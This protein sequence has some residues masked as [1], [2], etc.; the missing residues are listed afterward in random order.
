MRIWARATSITTVICLA[1]L[2]FTP[3]ARA[4]TAYR[5][6]TFWTMSN[7]QWVFSQVGP[8]S[9]TPV[10]GDVQAWRFAVSTSAS[11]SKFPPRTEPAT[12]FKTICGS[13]VKPEGRIRVAM[14]IDPGVLDSAPAGQSPPPAR[15]ACAVIGETGSGAEALMTIATPRVKGGM[16][17]GIDDYPLGECVLT[18]DISAT[19]VSPD[20]VS[21]VLAVPTTGASHEPITA[22]PASTAGSPVPLIAVGLIIAFG[23]IAAWLV[24]RR[25]V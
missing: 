18:I 25:R 20:E 10:D 11:G 8:A 4:Q 19:T 15:G 2:V 3:A 6:W 22:A 14:F 13:V 24:Q 9:T 16:V 23:L 1:V 5:Y 12:A 17:C 21:D 7:G